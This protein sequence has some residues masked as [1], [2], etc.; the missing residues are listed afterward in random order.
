ML[1]FEPQTSR[2]QSASDV[3]YTR[4]CAPTQVTDVLLSAHWRDPSREADSREADEDPY[5]MPCSQQ[6]ATGSNPNRH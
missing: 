5:N 1:R 3:C 6:P 4:V 2:T